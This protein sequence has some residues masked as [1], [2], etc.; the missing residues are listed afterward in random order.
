MT[1]HKE[2]VLAELDELANLTNGID[3]AVPE[4]FLAQLEAELGPREEFLA[5][6]ALPQVWPIS[7]DCSSEFTAVHHSGTRNVK[8]VIYIVLH[9]TQS[10]SAEAAARWFTQSAS[11]GSANLCTDHIECYRSLL[12]RYIPWAAP[13]ANTLGWHLEI[14]GYADWSRA[15][16]FQEKMR[17]DRSAWKAA[18]HAKYFSIPM[19]LLTVPELRNGR[20]HG[21]TTHKR[22]SDAFGGTHYDPGPN[23]PLDWFMDRVRYH[24]VRINL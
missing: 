16:W 22:C 11:R 23:F 20:R 13:G 3:C 9:C 15:R 14:A 5:A 8:T 7:K 18:L 12:P 4:S 19:R 1:T 17:L 24:A 2:I 6:K 10:N 21:F